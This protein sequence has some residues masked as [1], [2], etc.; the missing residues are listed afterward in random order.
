MDLAP[1]ALRYRRGATRALSAAA[2]RPRDYGGNTYLGT[3][4]MKPDRPYYYCASDALQMGEVGA[5]NER[6]QGM[7]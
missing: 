6:V 2:R 4:G 5:A 7:I 1:P 3:F